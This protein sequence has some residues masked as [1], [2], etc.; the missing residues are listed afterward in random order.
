MVFDTMPGAR[1]LPNQTQ[2]KAFDPYY[3]MLRDKARTPATH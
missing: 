2:L 1:P 3:K